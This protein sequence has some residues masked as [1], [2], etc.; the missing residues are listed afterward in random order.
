[1]T[2]PDTATDNPVHGYPRNLFPVGAVLTVLHGS[3]ERPYCTLGNLY[4][5]LGYLT[6]DVPG[7][8]SINSAIGTVRPWVRQQH[9][10]LAN[11]Q[12]PEDGA[13]DATVLAWLA[14]VEADHGATITL[15]PAPTDN[16]QE[17]DDV[18]PERPE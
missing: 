15:D 9:P 17:I 16:A 2:H 13:D 12:P 6:G 14:A 1:M 4:R 5:V 18:Q 8:D 3:N 7:A 11:L 10:A